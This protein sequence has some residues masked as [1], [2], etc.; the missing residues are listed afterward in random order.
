MIAAYGNQRTTDDAL[1]A[2]TT[3]DKT[4]WAQGLLAGEDAL[5][6]SIGGFEQRVYFGSRART[7]PSWARRPA[8][9]PWARPALGDGSGD[10]ADADTTTTYDGS[11]GVPMGSTFRRLMYAGEVQRAELPA[12]G[13]VNDNSQVLCNRDPSSRVEKFA[14][15]LTVDSD[16]YPVVADGKIPWASTGTP[17]PTATRARSASRSTR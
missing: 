7:T 17:R 6:T 9:N 15:W 14:P 3:D 4:Q 1:P 12:L 5:S 10:A 11:G 16:P 13:R 2:G 8:R